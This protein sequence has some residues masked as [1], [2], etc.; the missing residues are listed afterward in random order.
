MKKEYGRSMIEMLGVLAIIGVLSIGGLAGYTM[1]MNRHRAN[2]V[3][4]YV[5]RCGV[6][7][8]TR[9]SGAAADLGATTCNALMTDTAPIGNAVDYQVSAVN[10]NNE[11]TLTTPNLGT[12]VAE[13]I[14][15]RNSANANPQIA[16]GAG[17]GV[18]VFTFEI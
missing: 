4:E 9:G 18:I 7:A 10:A 5:S 13:A 2:S 16:A 8:Q 17:E 6:L 1:A 11:F 3:L 14:T 12:A 15:T